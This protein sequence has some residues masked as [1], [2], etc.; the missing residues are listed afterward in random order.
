M[1]SS[2]KVKLCTVIASALVLTGCLVSEDPILTASNG[3]ATPI[4]PGAYIM[5]PLSDDADEE[6]CEAFTIEHDTSGLYNFIKED[7]EPTQM[8]FRR[9][10]HRGFAVQLSEDDG[11]MYYYGAGNSNRFQLIMMMCSDLPE[12]MRARLIARGDLETEDDDFES[13]AVKT[14]KG[15]TNAAWAYHRGKTNSNEENS[16]LEFTPVSVE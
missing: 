7:E 13:C 2:L 8:R 11:Y 16:A 1:P 14:I 4:A 10:G 9:I 12:K 3:S 15:L 6:D 5:C